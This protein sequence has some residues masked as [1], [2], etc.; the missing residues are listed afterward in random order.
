MA[1]YIYGKALQYY[2]FPSIVS[3]TIKAL[4]VRTVGG[5]TAD[6]AV[7]RY[8]SAIAVGDRIASF[9]LDGKTFTNGVFNANDGTFGTPAA[10]VYGAVIL[11]HDTGDA[12]TSELLV[13]INLMSGLPIDHAGIN[14]IPVVWP[15]SGIFLL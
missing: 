3:D 7:D 11:Y 15:T 8:L 6:P 13:N 14:E 1:N 5:Y 10:G 4:L 9:T 2:S 12:A